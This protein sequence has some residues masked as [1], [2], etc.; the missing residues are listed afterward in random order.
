MS[1]NYSQTANSSGAA[2]FGLK[3][4]GFDFSSAAPPLHPG[5]FAFPLDKK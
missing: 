4:A 3:A 2:A 5:F 1:S